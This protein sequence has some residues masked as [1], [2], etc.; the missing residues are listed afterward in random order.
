MRRN[1][2]S[3]IFSTFSSNVERTNIDPIFICKTEIFLLRILSA[4][5]IDQTKVKMMEKVFFFFFFS[6][7]RTFLSLSVSEIFYLC[8]RHHDEICF[9]SEDEKKTS[10]VILPYSSSSQCSFSNH[11]VTSRSLSNLSDLII[12]N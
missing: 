10:V 3:V 7:I 2:T 8:L 5:F 9:H 6:D 12:E 4:L 1:Q 11:S